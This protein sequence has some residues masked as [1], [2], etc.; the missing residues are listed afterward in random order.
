MLFNKITSYYKMSLSSL[1]DIKSEMSDLENKIKK[2]RQEKHKVNLISKC[3]ID[4]K[5]LKKIKN[6]SVFATYEY[7]NDEQDEYGHTAS[8]TLKV[9]YTD[10][11]NQHLTVEYYEK[12]G[13]DTPNG[14][15]DPTIDCDITYS[16]SN[17]IIIKEI[18]ELCE[19]EY[20]WRDFIKEITE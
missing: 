14:R 3:D 7:M 9:T 6:L 4:N 11:K 15:Y 1:D 20:E 2:L 18:L 5:K 19:E 16:N 12:Q 10:N 13:Y 8:A 17:S